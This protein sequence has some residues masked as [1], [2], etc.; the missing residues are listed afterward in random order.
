MKEFKLNG[1]NILIYPKE[2]CTPA[3]NAKLIDELKIKTYTHYINPELEYH[4]GHGHLISLLDV[5]FSK[6]NVLIYERR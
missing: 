3:F 2:K 1:W 6:E 4:N 5:D